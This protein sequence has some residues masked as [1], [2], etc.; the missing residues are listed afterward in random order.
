MWKRTCGPGARNC[1]R[2]SEVKRRSWKP[3]RY[4]ATVLRP[5]AARSLALLACAMIGCGSQ[6]P[7]ASPSASVV[8]RQSCG[9]CHTLIG[10]ESARKQ[11]GD[12][13]GYRLTR[14]Q[15]LGLTREMPVRRP[16]S[17]AQLQAVT[18]YVLGAE[19]RGPAGR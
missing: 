4:R 8:F 9:G 5:C 11:G 7:P 10:N 3:W 15:L 14:A 6:P 13:L 17:S 16:L 18:D 2:R 19:R 1:L 12:L